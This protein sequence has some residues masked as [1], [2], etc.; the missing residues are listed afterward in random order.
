MLVYE[1]SYYL[2]NP[3]EIVQ[4]YLGGMS[5]HGGVLGALVGAYIAH[6]DF[7]KLTD[8]LC[9]VA[10][11]II[12]LGRIANFLN[13]ELWGRVTDL[14]IGVIFTGADNLPRH[15]SQLYEALLEGPLLA[16]ILF[17][18]YKTYQKKRL[19]FKVGLLSCYYLIF[20]SILRF[21][22]EFTRE[23][24][25]FL[26]LIG[27]FQLLSMGQYLSLIY[28]VLGLVVL[29]LRIRQRQIKSEQ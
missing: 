21:L 6:M 11:I 25:A 16:I 20:Y 27:P 19:Y 9:I 1:P 24:D 13:G 5:Y 10:L 26:G 18:I 22:V 7:F 17:L 4:I 2:R 8:R 14:P 29:Y 3:L 23:P 28:L 12:P 15:P